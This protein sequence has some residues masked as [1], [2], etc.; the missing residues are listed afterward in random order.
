M[1][2]LSH[3]DP[4]VNLVHMQST[5]RILTIQCQLLITGS[6]VIPLKHTKGVILLFTLLHLHTH[7][8]TQSVTPFSEA[9]DANVLFPVLKCCR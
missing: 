4:L 9:C 6:H 5:T 2:F 1:V 3:N 8:H 7:T